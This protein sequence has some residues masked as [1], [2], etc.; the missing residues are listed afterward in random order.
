MA[1]LPS[2]RDAGD[3]EPAASGEGDE[4]ACASDEDACRMKVVLL[5]LFSKITTR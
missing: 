4:E 3:C 1:G 2:L 5:I